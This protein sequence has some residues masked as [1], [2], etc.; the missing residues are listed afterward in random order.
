[1][2]PQ[3]NPLGASVR[4]PKKYWYRIGECYARETGVTAL[5]D[6]QLWWRSALH[7]P[8]HVHGLLWAIKKAKKRK[9]RNLHNIMH[10]FYIF[11]GNSITY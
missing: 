7:R 8:R 9:T 3:G 11:Y 1:M 2:R 10:F 6:V 4:A 5:R